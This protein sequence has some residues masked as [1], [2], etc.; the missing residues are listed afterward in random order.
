MAYSICQ[1][2]LRGHFSWTVRQA[3]VNVGRLEHWKAQ[4]CDDCMAILEKAVL[5]AF[6]LEG[7]E[8]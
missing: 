7:G 5:T 3:E 4:L 8:K 6:R 2:C 1:R